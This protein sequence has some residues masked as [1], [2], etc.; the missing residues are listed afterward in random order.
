MK[1]IFFTL[2]GFSFCLGSVNS[3][4]VKRYPFAAAAVGCAGAALAKHALTKKAGSHHMSLAEKYAAF[5]SLKWKTLAQNDTTFFLLNLLGTLCLGAEGFCEGTEYG[6]SLK[7]ECTQDILL[8]ASAINLPFTSKEILSARNTTTIGITSQEKLTAKQKKEQVL[9]AGCHHLFKVAFS[10]KEYHI[11]YDWNAQQFY[12]RE[13]ALGAKW[14]PSNGLRK[15]QKISYKDDEGN[16]HVLSTDSKIYTTKNNNLQEDEDFKNIEQ[17]IQ[18]AFFYKL[19][20]YAGDKN[21]AQITTTKE[22]DLWLELFKLECMLK[23][24]NKED[25]E[26]ALKPRGEISLRAD[27]LKK[28]AGRIFDKENF[29]SFVEIL[30]AVLL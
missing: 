25:V 9:P 30:R 4:S 26:K 27:F 18:N 5:G 1:N 6:Q 11:T 2:L 14:Y 23:A 13:G 12:V 15:G 3:F 19:E 17:K 7:L 22:A 16:I 8:P 28:E 29:D 24:V 21:P 10:G 20:K